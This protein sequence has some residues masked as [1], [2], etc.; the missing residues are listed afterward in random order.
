MATNRDLGIADATF[1]ADADLTAK[2]YFF[3]VPASTAG[4]VKLATGASDPTPVGV[5][6][7]SPSAGQEARGRVLGFSKVVAESTSTCGMKWGRF[8]AAGS[9]GAFVSGCTSGLTGCAFNAR[10]MDSNVNSG[11]VIGQVFLFTNFAACA[12]AGS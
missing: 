3:V 6:Q 11:S 7:N 12:N 4:N 10:W 9:T 1:T 8:G 2:Q 5:L